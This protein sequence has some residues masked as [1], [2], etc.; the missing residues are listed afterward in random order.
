MTI[1][2][3]R[4]EGPFLVINCTLF[5][6]RAQQSSELPSQKTGKLFSDIAQSCWSCYWW[7][8]SVFELVQTC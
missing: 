5:R 7:P 1:E 4:H 8:S 6:D 3:R 2:G